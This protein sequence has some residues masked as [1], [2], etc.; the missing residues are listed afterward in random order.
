M[1]SGAAI[2][3]MR[4]R[5]PTAMWTSD[6]AIGRTSTPAPRAA[7]GCWFWLTYGRAM[8]PSAAICTPSRAV[9]G[10]LPGQERQIDFE[11]FPVAGSWRENPAATGHVL[12]G[13]TLRRKGL[14]AGRRSIQSRS[15][16]GRDNRR[17]LGASRVGGRCFARRDDR[18]GVATERTPDHRRR[19]PARQGRCGN[20]GLAPVVG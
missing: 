12:A 18:R 19:L 8:A 7:M 3:G 10:L 20:A 17:P 11:L 1:E 2:R 13:P 4:R 14:F 9:A 6:G 5:D 16:D 15:L